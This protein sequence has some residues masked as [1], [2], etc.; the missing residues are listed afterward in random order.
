VI[1]QKPNASPRAP[2]LST[3]ST[4]ARDREDATRDDRHRVSV[5]ARG[6]VRSVGRSRADASVD[7]VDG[8]TEGAGDEA[9]AAWRRRRWDARMRWRAGARARERDAGDRRGM[10]G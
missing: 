1:G 2:T 4:D 7:A 3:A 9:R 5:V 6:R 8:G 10:C